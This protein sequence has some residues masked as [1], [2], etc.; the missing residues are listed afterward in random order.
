MAQ[1]KLKQ[2]DSVL[3]GSLQVSGSSGVTG[4]LDVSSTG[5]F[6]R[7]ISTTFSGDGSGLANVFE[8]TTPSSSISTRVTALEL[9]PGGIFVATGSIH[10]TRANL[11]VSGS[12]LIS[13]STLTV[14]TGTDSGPPTA[15]TA[16]YT[17]NITN[18]YPFRR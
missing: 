16:I 8:G 15:S 18:G 9:D 17:N 12:L 3:T 2:L 6:G 10:S 5:S 7:V 11:Q 13:G 14:R 4:S 1:L